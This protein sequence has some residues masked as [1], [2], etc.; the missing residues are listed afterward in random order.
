M[1]SAVLD[2]SAILAVLNGEAGAELV[3]PML[4]TAVASTVNVAEV[5]G[6]LIDRGG[7]LDDAMQAL[8]AI[9]LDVVDYDLALAQ[10]TAS[11]RTEPANRSLSL[12]DRAC[13]ALA[14]REGVPAL[15]CDQS[16]SR[17]VTSANIEFAR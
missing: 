4:A 5:L 2:S 11:L 13:L 7:S 16:W 15:T 6:K 10:R 8:D 9:D 14:E 17:A 3:I 1:T 12:G